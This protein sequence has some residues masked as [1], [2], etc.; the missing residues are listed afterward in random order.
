MERMRCSLTRM[1]AEARPKGARSTRCKKPINGDQQDQ[2]EIIKL[3]GAFEIEGLETG[4]GQ[5]GPDVDVMP[6][7]AAAEL[8]VVEDEVEHLREGESDHD[9]VDARGAHDE[10]ADDESGVELRRVIAA[11]SVSQRLAASYFGAISASA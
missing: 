4:D 5:L 11:G 7:R 3:H 1:P 2:R 9:E 10:K 8:G 6:S